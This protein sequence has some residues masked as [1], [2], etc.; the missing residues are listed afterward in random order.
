MEY[1]AI[2]KCRLCNKEFEDACTCNK[3]LVFDCMI[4]MVC[5]TKLGQPLE[6]QKLNLHCC[7]DKS[8][9]LADFQG[10][11]SIDRENQT[12]KDGD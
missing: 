11:K 2:Y 12:K 4:A 5:D 9:G 3:G 8:M 1:R 10:W 6:P 7:D